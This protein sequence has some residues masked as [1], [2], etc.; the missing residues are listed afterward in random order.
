MLLC[1]DCGGTMVK[2][3]LVRDRQIIRSARIPS[4]AKQG[5]AALLPAL[6]KL[7]ASMCAAEGIVIRDCQGI[8]LCMPGLI[9]S[10]SAR[11]LSPPKDKYADAMGV[12]LIRWSQEKFNLPLVLENDA[13]AA[14][15]GEWRCGAGAGCGDLVMV[16]L[17]TGIG[18]SVVIQGKLLRGK[19][20]QAGVLGGH[21]VINPDGEPCGCGGRGCIESETSIRTLACLAR[22]DA[23]FAASALAKV[24]NPDYA[25]FFNAAAAGDDLAMRLVIRSLNLWASHIVSLIHAFDPERVVMG[26]GI[27]SSA[28]RIL[29][30][31]QPFVDARAW[32]PWGRVQVVPAQHGSDA[33]LLGLSVLLTEKLSYV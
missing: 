11:F 1:A 21:F 7:F 26:G 28:A 29:S 16:T 24:E 10:R 33:S 18:V 32:T 20:G 31:I 8:A 30:H 12:D 4:Q 6:E 9:D 27:M 5:L 22:R 19:H 3:G 2:A 13:H 14:C 25:A 17:G 15:I 23:A